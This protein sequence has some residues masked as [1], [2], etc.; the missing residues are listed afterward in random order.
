MRFATSSKSSSTVALNLENLRPQ[1]VQPKAFL[2]LSLEH[3]DR[4]YE[5]IFSY[6]TPAPRLP[7]GLVFGG[8]DA[9]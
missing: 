7:V 2:S 8:C 6:T 4:I 3:R 1:R 9:G 5:F